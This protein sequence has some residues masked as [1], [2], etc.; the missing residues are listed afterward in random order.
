MWRRFLATFLTVTAI[1][2]A[3]GLVLGGIGYAMSDE[4]RADDRWLMF[5]KLMLL[6]AGTS[7]VVGILT[8]F[9]MMSPRDVSL[10]RTISKIAGA[11][12]LGTLLGASIN[13]TFK[14]QPNPLWMLLPMVAAAVLIRFTGDRW[15]T[16]ERLPLNSPESNEQRTDE[17]TTHPT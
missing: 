8:G 1:G 7:F 15:T 17:P 6:G 13:P 9:A 12:I 2:I 16:K 14:G 3:I 5:T 10:I 11:G 4:P